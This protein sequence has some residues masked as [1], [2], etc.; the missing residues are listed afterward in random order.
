MS[1]FTH[2]LG[3]INKRLVLPQPLKYRIMKEIA[4]DLEDT[5]QAYIGQ[6]L[7]DTETE[8]K[9]LEKIAADDTVIEQL[10]EIHETPARKI[11]RRL[12]D[13]MRR[14]IELTLWATLIVVVGFYITTF[15]FRSENLASSPFNWLTGAFIVCMSGISVWKCYHIYIKRDH[16]PQTI[17]RGLSLLIF[18]S[19]LTM[20][21]AILGF[22]TELQLSVSLSRDG[23]VITGQSVEILIRSITLISFGILAAVSGAIAW[24]IL[25]LKTMD[26]EDREN[27]FLFSNPTHNKGK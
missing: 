6:G 15:L 17:H 11:L 25:T 26:I 1:R 23:K 27:V 20:L 21:M 4:A 14:R 8:S 18:I 19:G 5:F 7:S 24:L 13:K 12:S 9:A 2:I 10:M 3:G 22:F 16:N